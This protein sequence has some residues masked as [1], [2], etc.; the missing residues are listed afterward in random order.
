MLLLLL[1]L[2]RRRLL[3]LR[4]RQQQPQPHSD[5]GGECCLCVWQNMAGG[6]AR[7]NTRNTAQNRF[8]VWRWQNDAVT[9]VATRFLCAF[10]N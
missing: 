10:W 3:L 7:T 8:N 6:L 5:C 2:R 1:L 9:P 4:R